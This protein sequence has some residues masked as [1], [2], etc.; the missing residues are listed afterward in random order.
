[1]S[2]SIAN[3]LEH[4]IANL[5]EHHGVAPPSPPLESFTKK[6]LMAPVRQLLGEG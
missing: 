3:L 5:L 4:H 2:P 6:E 1:M